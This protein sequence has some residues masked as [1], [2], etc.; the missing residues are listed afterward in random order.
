MTFVYSS[1]SLTITENVDRKEALVIR[2]NKSAKEM[3]IEMPQRLCGRQLNLKENVCGH[4]HSN[5]YIQPESYFMTEKSGSFIQASHVQADKIFLENTHL[6]LFSFFHLYSQLIIW[7]PMFCLKE[8]MYWLQP[9]ES[10]GHCDSS[11]CFCPHTVLLVVHVFL[12]I[13]VWV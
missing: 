13:G 7:L 12:V 1:Q 2:E 6:F 5:T 10:G 3:E 4:T 9:Q 11:G 8:R